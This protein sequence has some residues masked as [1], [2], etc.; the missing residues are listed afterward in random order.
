MSSYRQYKRA[1]EIVVGKEGKGLIFGHGDANRRLRVVFEVTKTLASEPNEAIVKIYNLNEQHYSAL[2]NEYEDLLLNAGYE[3]NM[4]LLFRGNIRHVDRYRDGLDWITEI[5]CGDGDKDFRKAIMNTTLAAGT[6][7]QQLVDKAIGSF[8]TTKKGYTK[9]V[10]SAKRTRGKVVSGNTRTV[11]NDIARQHGATWSIQDGKL[12]IVETDG[13]LDTEA[14]VLNWNTGLLEPPK[15]TEQGIDVKCLLNPFM[16]IN[17]RVKLD[18]AAIRAHKE[19]ERD[20]HK[21]TAEGKKQKKVEKKEDKKETT[22]KTDPDGVYKIYKI[23]HSGDTHGTGGDWIS[24][25]SSVSMDSSYPKSDG[26]KK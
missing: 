13:V 16:Q 22:N 6:S 25:V 2:K 14:I 11:L 4:Q 8:S 3:G 19:K 24:E 26:A 20:E 15:Q 12:Q 17:G 18:N 10:K 5:D 23:K 7:D 21:K 9:G 1:V